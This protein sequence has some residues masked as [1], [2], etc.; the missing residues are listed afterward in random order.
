MKAGIIDILLEA[1]GWVWGKT[2]LFALA[3][4]TGVGIAVSGLAA[5]ARVG[6]SFS[7]E[8]GDGVFADA[9]PVL[10][11]GL[12]IA[13]ALFITALW[14]VRS[15]KAGLTSWTAVAV[16]LSLVVT[17]SLCGGLPHRVLPHL[18]AW[19]MVAG[20]IVVLLKAVSAFRRWQLRRQEAHS[21]SLANANRERREYLQK[22]FGTVSS[23]AADLG[24]VE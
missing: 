14:W 9:V 1:A 23:S 16:S 12:P 17:G 2:F 19:G 18:V 6:R 4:L 24:F 5:G 13:A 8:S 22:H 11:I 15:E 3:V 21:E 10:G 20:L 7:I